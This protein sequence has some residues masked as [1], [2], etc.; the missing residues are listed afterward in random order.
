[1]IFRSCRAASR[2]APG[3]AAASGTFE[4]PT[5]EPR[6]EGLT[7]Q[8]KPSVSATRRAT[9]AGSS[10]HSRR[11]TTRYSTIGRPWAAKTAFI[12]ALSMPTAEA[13]TPA[14]T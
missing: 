9:G 5:E 11:A 7:K 13:R 4:I 2:I 8:G 1:M 14:P 3:S 12:I 10:R 6:F